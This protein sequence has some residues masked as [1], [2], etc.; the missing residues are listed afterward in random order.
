MKPPLMLLLPLAWGVLAAAPIGAPVKESPGFS[1]LPNS[2]SRNPLLVMT[3]FTEMTEHGRTLTPASVE[4]PVYFTA[5]EQGLRV[6]GETM[7]GAHPPA[8]AAM[9]E[10]LFRTLAQ[11]GYLPV[12]EGRPAGLALVYFWGSHYGMEPEDAAMFPAQSNRQV[13]ERAMLVG[14][15]AFRR[16]VANQLTFGYTIADR[17]PDKAFLVEQAVGDLYF[18]VVSAYDARELAAGHRR[19]A[20]RTTMT[21]DSR[22]VAMIESL[23]PLITSAAGYFGHET[24]EPVVIQRRTRRGTVSLGALNFSDEVPAPPPPASP[25]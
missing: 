18:F 3:V 5:I 19:L 14:G 6:M 4:A 16:R 24:A 9:R 22:G 20:W 23:P 8:P 11:G 13:L 15:S 21:V 1:L 7:G 17:T 2:L 12:A 10:V 25:K